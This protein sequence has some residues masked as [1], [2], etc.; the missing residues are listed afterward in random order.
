MNWQVHQ[1]LGGRER[2]GTAQMNLQYRGEG[3]TSGAAV[4]TEDPSVCSQ[5]V[6]GRDKFGRTLAV[7]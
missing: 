1:A 3:F 4:V 6:S 2:P 5:P 7:G